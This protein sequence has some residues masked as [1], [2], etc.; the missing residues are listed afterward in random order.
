MAL[1][2]H[3]E[4]PLL[5]YTDASFSERRRAPGECAAD[6]PGRRL[7]GALGSVVWDPVGGC[8]RFAYAEPPW[9]LLLSSWRTD[10]RTYIAE[11]ETLA[12]IAVYSTYPELFR[13]R[14]VNHFIDNTVALSAMVHGYSGK[15]DLAKQVNVFYLQAIKLRA[16][17]YFDYV[18]SKANMADLPSRRAFAATRAALAGLRI[19]GGAPDP[20]VVPGVAQWAAPI[21]SWA[22]DSPALDTTPMAA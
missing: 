19:C 18:P 13:G 21:G 6:E 9:R 10:R 4:P 14:R 11:L 12:A 3:L 17:V 2:P 15:P 16:H 20:L 5:V 7:D 22:S 8:A 1:R